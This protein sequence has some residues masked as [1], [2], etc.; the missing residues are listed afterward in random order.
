MNPLLKQL[1][2]LRRK[3]R[4]LDGWIGV[5]A[6]VALVCTVGA[7]AGTFDYFFQVPSL[8]RAVMLTG[9]LTTSGIV[10]YA[11][12][13]RPFG[14]KCDDL[15]LAL[16]VEEVYPELNDALASTVQFLKLTPDEQ[17]GVGGSDAMRQ[18]TMQGALEKA[19]VYDFSQI[20]NRRP[21]MLFSLAGLV[22]GTFLGTL[23]WYFPSHSQTA[24]RRFIEPFGSHPWTSISVER[25]KGKHSNLEA[26][27]PKTNQQDRIALNQPYRIRVT[28]AGKMPKHAKV[29]IQSQIRSELT[30]TPDKLRMEDDGTATFESPIPVPQNSEKLRY[31]I[32]ANDGLFPPRAGT[33]FEVDVLPKPRLIDL[34]KGAPSP[35]ITIYP[36]TY[37]DLPSPQRLPGGTK[38]LLNLFEG[39][40]VVLRAKAD[41]PLVEAWI[42]LHPERNTTENRDDK[43]DEKKLPP[44]RIQAQF[45]TND[46]SVMNFTFTPKQLGE[47]SLYIKDEHGL[48]AE[49]RGQINL[50]RDPL[51]LVKLIRPSAS[52]TAIPT[53]SIAFKFQ[54]TDDIFAVKSVWL[55]YRKKGPDGQFLEEP[56]KRVMMYDADDFRWL[57]PHMSALMMKSPF[58]GPDAGLGRLVTHL[59]AAEAKSPERAEQIRLRW[60]RLDFDSVWA[61]N[62]EFK[63]G[64]IVHV[65]VCSDDFHNLNLPREPGRSHAIELRIITRP[66][67]VRKAEE[68]LADINSQLKQMEKQQRKALDAVREAQKVDKFDQKSRE[69]FIDGA[70]TP[71]REIEN[72]IGK[73]ADEGLRR[74]LN[75]LRQQLKESKLDNTDVFR[76]AS[77]IKGALENI[78]QEDLPQIEPKLAD[79]Q[80]QIAQNDKN[81]PQIKKNLEAVAR[82]QE[83]VAKGLKELINDLD[84]QAAMREQAQAIR[85]IAQAQEQINQKLD[86][87][88]ALKNEL[89]KAQPDQK[90]V[91]EKVTR[92]KIERQMREQKELA[93]KTEKLIKQLKT[94]QKELEEK[95]DK[96]GA[97]RIEEAI[98]NIEQPKAN[99]PM[100]PDEQK[101]PLNTQMRDVAKQ[102]D[103]KAE[104]K[105][106]T[107]D[108]QK[109]I[110]KNLDQAI[111]AL[112]GRDQNSL[113]QAI[114]ERQQMEKNL[115]K[116]G[117]ELKQL[118]DEQKKIDKIEN[119]EERLKKQQE[120]AKKHEELQQKIEKARRA[121][122]RLDEQRPA[123]DLNDAAKQLEN[124]A[125]KIRNGENADAEQKKAQQKIQQAREELKEAEEEL[126]R[127]MLIRMADQLGGLKIRQDSQLK[128]AE[129]LHA[130]VMKKESW[131]E[132]LLDTMDGNL[133]AQKSIGEE[134]EQLKDKMK[135]AKVFASILERAK[136]SMDDAFTTMKT[137]H[138]EGKDRR[139][140]DK[141]EKMKKEELKD[142]IE[143]Q[144]DTVKNQKQAALR[145]DRIIE[146][147]KEEI[148]KKKPPRKEQKDPQNADNMP[149]DK[150]EPQGGLR[151]QDGIP[152]MAQI[153]ALRSE[154]EDLMRDTK[155]FHQRNP[156]AAQYNDMQRTALRELETRQEELQSLFQ[157]LIAPP[158][159]KEGDPQ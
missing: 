41:R 59:A 100:T 4:F 85:D 46:R 101:R 1:A 121:L 21:A 104:T 148:A 111:K 83:N 24:F 114:E 44:E 130:K 139:Y 135:G 28:L 38:D 144:A 142:E 77:K 79:A 71:Q 134:T 145:L 16:R 137:R 51:P 89:E 149:E 60:K 6:L 120:L 108:Q 10:G 66:E 15:T 62:N 40:K 127:E 98:K 61:L 67:M 73:A 82:M 94:A 17:A 32:I 2:S 75:E 56:M 14:K 11:Y 8:L 37:T 22:A 92:E 52:V 72:I 87:A 157:G 128:R 106:K 33:W 5:W 65:E 153:K 78:A 122:A 76:D 141:N 96:E 112:E 30:F 26:I 147:L 31:K 25:S 91:I 119:M 42:E 74:D 117:K 138:E 107:L 20:L 19:A 49:E 150:K 84:P 99:D 105:Q 58:P 97:S 57:I 9:L 154:Q 27:D 146:S 45:D 151:A 102:L 81:S 136:K 34:E 29:L 156:D 131:T 70:Q 18:R 88:N 103:N 158:M 63:A 133:N 53:A 143:W 68:K 50:V 86:E 132:P 159:P 123:N 47:Y 43:A 39:S 113:R 95:G 90:A 140:A 109:E 54:A 118:Q 129:D 23:I 155:D 125:D 124:A 80:N 35:Q 116:I 7:S 152:P 93:D 55:E 3:V 69:D 48:D 64:D 13:I 36:P 126:A 110:A 12:I 115:D